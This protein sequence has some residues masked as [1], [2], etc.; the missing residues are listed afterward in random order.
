[1]AGATGVAELPPEPAEAMLQQFDRLLTGRGW[2]ARPRVI[3]SQEKHQGGR[4]LLRATPCPLALEGVPIA[5]AQGQLT[6][7]TNGLLKC[8][9]GP[10]PPWRRT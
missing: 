7:K 5:I 3:A 6:L 10:P 9:I 1:M 8:S 4:Q 2:L